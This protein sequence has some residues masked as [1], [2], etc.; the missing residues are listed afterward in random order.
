MKTDRQALANTFLNSTGWGRAKCMELSGDAS[1]RHY[2]RMISKNGE[3]AVLMDVPP[4]LSAT[5]AP[6]ISI[7]AHLDELGFS[8]PKILHVDQ[9]NG[10]LLLED[11]GDDLFA[12]VVIARPENEMVI[13]EAAVDFLIALH[14]YPPPDNCA[15]HSAA[16]MA[17]KTGLAY[18]FYAQD[19][20]MGH[21]QRAQNLLRDA[22]ER[23]RPFAAVLALRDFH[24]E[25]LIWLPG[26][27]G[28]KRVGLLDFQDAFACHPAYDLISLTEDAR[29]DLSSGL[30]QHLSQRYIAKTGQ[31]EEAFLAASA[32]IAAQRNLRILGVFARLAIRDGKPRYIN[33][34]PRVWGHL[35]SDLAHP[36]LAELRE[37]ITQD[38]PEPTPSFM[39][40]LRDKCATIQAP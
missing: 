38:L 20:V 15:Q 29:R 23:H 36:D 39:Q 14:R 27:K 4:D 2:K 5:I 35:V 31:D 37:M 12:R 21:K 3:T 6:F 17:E 25:N 1:S 19:S 40:N 28:S 8:P 32:A 10:F 26:R 22:L 24:A 18:D 34:L 16:E 7:A 30:A 9:K 13:Y 33:F 11:L